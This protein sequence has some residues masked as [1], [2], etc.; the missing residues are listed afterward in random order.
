L[1]SRSSSN[2]QAPDPEWL[3]VGRVGKPHGIHGDVLVE[4]ITDFPDRL[5]DGLKFGIG[6][7]DGPESFHLVHRVRF[8][9]RRWLLSVKGVRDR[10]TVETWR[11]LFV[12]LPELSL[13]EL[14]NG[15]YY[16]HHLVGLDCVSST[17]EP[18]G[19]VTGLETGG[20]QSRLVIQHRG[21]E[22]LVPYVPAI[23]LQV[24]LD[25]GRILLDPP[26]GLLDDDV[27]IAR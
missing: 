25:Q 16:E 3:I 9:K 17:G 8:H 10:A 22:H 18:L 26:P 5:V 4:I 20:G 23:V 7:D 19:V 24:D 12:Y 21:S 15:Y 6:G 14:P 2:S 11:G 13:D 1:C 27:I